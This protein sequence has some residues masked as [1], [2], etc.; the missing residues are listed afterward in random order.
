MQLVQS[1]NPIRDAQKVP[2]IDCNPDFDNLLDK[3]N[4]LEVLMKQERMD[5]DVI[6]YLPG[7]IKI[8]YQG[9]IYSIITK[10][11]FPDS[12]YKDKQVLEFN[13]N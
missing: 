13:I 11:K 9:L 7:I 8:G 6:R 5:T 10:R 1:L 4:K 3:V 12:T 2:P